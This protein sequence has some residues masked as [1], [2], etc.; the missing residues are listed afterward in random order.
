MSQLVGE[1]ICPPSATL[2]ILTSVIIMFH[3]D[4]TLRPVTT[5]LLFFF[6]LSRMCRLHM[7]ACH[8]NGP[9]AWLLVR[10]DLTLGFD[11]S[12]SVAW[13]GTLARCYVAPRLIF[14]CGRWYLVVNLVL[15]EEP[16]GYCG[17]EAC[18]RKPRVALIALS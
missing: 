15:H 14:G 18:L 7:S 12:T 10:T 6:F 3:N 9:L 13:H 5:T 16:T 11:G 4:N 8:G 1:P 2:A 17:S